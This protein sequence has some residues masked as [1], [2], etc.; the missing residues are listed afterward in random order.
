MSRVVACTLSTSDVRS[1]LLPL[2]IFLLCRS[3][4][5]VSNARRLFQLCLPFRFGIQCFLR[6]IKKKEKRRTFLL[7]VHLSVLL[8]TLLRPFFFYLL[9]LRLF[10]FFSFRLISVAFQSFDDEDAIADLSIRM[11]PRLYSDRALLTVQVTSCSTPQRR[12]TEARTR[13]SGS[14]LFQ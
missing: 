2:R 5:V 10:L 12:M 3:T 6:S 9:G 11:F 4:A 8:S 1:F 7:H 13:W 14:M